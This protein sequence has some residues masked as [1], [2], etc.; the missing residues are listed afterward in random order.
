MT[1]K[2][3]KSQPTELELLIL[4]V[5][6]RAETDALPM[7]VREIRAGLS[8]WGRDLAHTTVITTLNVMVGK[9]FLKRSK[10]KNAFFFAP[11]VQEEKIQNTVVGDVLKRVFDGSAENLML[12]LLNQSDVDQ[13]TLA[14]IQAMIKRK[15]NAIKKQG[16]S[17]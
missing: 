13:D 3:Q 1:R 8:E 11:N 16:E 2:K 4:K 15:A 14:E 17:K 6:W 5:L 10:Q 12:T 7:P 9:K